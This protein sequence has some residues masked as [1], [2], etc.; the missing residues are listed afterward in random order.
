MSNHGGKTLYYMFLKPCI[1]L[2]IGI[3]ECNLHEKDYQ[4]NGSHIMKELGEFLLVSQ[5]TF[6]HFISSLSSCISFQK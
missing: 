5:F 2:P 6:S 3:L 4:E 1:S